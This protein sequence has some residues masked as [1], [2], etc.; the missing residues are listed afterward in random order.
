MAALWLRWCSA[1]GR[2][3]RWRIRAATS[4]AWP[5]RMAV[6]WVMTQGGGVAGRVQGPGGFPQVFQHVDQVN[7]D[8]DSHAAGGGF[9]L[10]RVDLVVVPVDEHDPVPLAA[11]VAA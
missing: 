2:G 9:L 3:S 1:P 10:D 11:G 5:C 8:R 7:H 4:A 6:A